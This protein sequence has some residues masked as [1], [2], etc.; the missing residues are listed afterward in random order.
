MKNTNDEVCLA[1]FEQ[2]LQLIRDRVTGVAQQYYC[3]CYL[4]GS[5]SCLHSRNAGMKRKAGSAKVVNAK[6][7]GVAPRMLEAG[8]TVACPDLVTSEHSVSETPHTILLTIV[9][10]I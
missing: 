3:G 6:R 5:L 8:M 7:L 1:S 10:R 4:V 9:R 2:K